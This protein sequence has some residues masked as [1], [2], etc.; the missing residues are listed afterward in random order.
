M[1]YNMNK[2]DGN[3]ACKIVIYFKYLDKRFNQRIRF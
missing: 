2:M 1:D 3:E